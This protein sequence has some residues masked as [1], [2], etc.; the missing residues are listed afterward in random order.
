MWNS[1]DLA[2]GMAALQASPIDWDFF[3]GCG[4]IATGA[5]AATIGAAL[6]T[7][8]TTMANQFR[9]KGGMIDAGDEATAAILTAYASTVTNRVLYAY[10]SFVASTGKA[11]PGWSAP[12]MR[13][14]NAFAQKAHAALLSTDLARVKSGPIPNAL[15]IEHNEQVT[16]VLDAAKISTARTIPGL[17]GFFLTN[18]NMKSAA[19]SDFKY[20]QH[21]RIMD[22]ACATVAAGQAIWLNADL[23]TNPDGTIDE[24]DA[25]AIESDITAKLNAKLVEP[26]NADG[27]PGHVS[28][29]EYKI[30]RLNNFQ[31]TGIVLAN[32]AVQPRGYVKFFTTTLGFVAKFPVPAVPAAA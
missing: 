15:S 17:T 23:R 24:R 2:T 7:H 21:R 10:R 19:G 13:L 6:Q 12:K 3:V 9:Y 31:T 18:G 22:V 14:V 1:A 4:R 28:R 25:I 11:F 30:D 26:R 20:W 8:L 29:L 5:A 27:K 16:E 32:L